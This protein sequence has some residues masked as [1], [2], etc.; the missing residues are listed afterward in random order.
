MHTA[1]EFHPTTHLAAVMSGRASCYDHR[2]F[3]RTM[4]RDTGVLRS[5]ERDQEIFGEGDAADFFFKVTCGTVRTYK[6]LVDGRRQIDAFHLPGD[7]FGLETGIEHRFAAEA[8]QGVK[9]RAFRRR[10]LSE[11]IATDPVAISDLMLA[12]ANSLERAQDHMLLLGRKCA[13]EKIATFLLKISE[14]ISNKR[15][16]ELSMSRTDIADHLGLTIE[17][18]SRT[19]TQLQRENVIEIPCGRRGIVL[20]DPSAL[21]HMDS[22][23][24]DSNDA[25][26]IRCH[27]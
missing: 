16:I 8:I 18:V 13:R 14:R 27:A 10:D 26:P 9:V 21:R 1:S 24:V 15:T 17:T 22:G 7:I 11:M 4:P 25:I 19:L 3:G 2:T 23:D 6:L 12:L 5:F 20:R